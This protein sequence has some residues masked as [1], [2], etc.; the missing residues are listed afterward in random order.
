M[1]IHLVTYCALLFFLSEL[2]L[3]LSKRSKQTRIKVQNDK[4]SLLLFWVTIP[5]SFTLG[6]SL[7][8][9]QPWNAFN[10]ALALFGLSLFLVGIIIRWT[11]I[12]QLNSAFT[13][14]V[15]ITKDHQLKTNGLYRNLRH[16]SYFGLLLICV[17]LAFAMNNILAW[18]VISFPVLLA[19]L[20][21]IKLEEQTLIME[22]GETYKHYLAKTYQLIPWVF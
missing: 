4:Q 13:V 7:A 12:V 6:F 1:N 5:L 18:A 22:F 21:R 11:A 20:Y 8:K 17:G 2:A 9:Y 19:L 16:P 15:I 3:V 10:N 14:A